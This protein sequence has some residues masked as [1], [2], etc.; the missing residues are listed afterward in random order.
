MAAPHVA[1]AAALLRAVHPDW[2]PADIKS[3]LVSTAFD[4][5]DDV[6][7]QG[8]GR[9]DVS[10]AVNQTLFLDPPTLGFG[11][12]DVER[13]VW[14]PSH[15]VRVTNRGSSPVTLAAPV[16]GASGAGAPQWS[17]TESGTTLAPG[18]SKDVLVAMS[19]DHRGS[20]FPT[21]GS[22]SYAGSV[23]IAGLPTKWAFVK[24]SRIRV[25][26]DQGLPEV[27]VSDDRR[28]FR[29]MT[30]GTHA[31]ESVI[32]AGTYDVVALIWHDGEVGVTVREQL[33]VKGTTA[34]A[35]AIADLKHTLT[36]A[37]V[38]EQGVP[39]ASRPRVNGVSVYKNRLRFVY[40]EGNLNRS[41]DTASLHIPR[42]LASDI[43]AGWR[44]LIGEFYADAPSSTLYSVQHP[45][46][47]G[48]RESVVL[49][50]QPL[51]ERRARVMSPN[52]PG[53]R[54]QVQLAFMRH[55]RF[56]DHSEFVWTAFATP[57]AA[58]ATW[59]GRLFLTADVDATY[60]FSPSIGLRAKNK[61]LADFDPVPLRL[62][63]ERGIA[64]VPGV[65][66]GP[67][68]QWHAP[69][70]TLILGGGPIHP[71]IEFTPL[72]QTSFHANVFFHGANGERR[73]YDLLHTRW[74]MFD[75]AGVSTGS[76]VMEISNLQAQLPAPGPVR[77]ELR[78]DRAKVGAIN[79]RA[80][81]RAWFDTTKPDAMAPSFTALSV[82]NGAGAQVDAL[83]F[84]SD[85]SLLFGIVDEQFTTRGRGYKTI[86]LGATRVEYR[87]SGTS[88]WVGAQTRL[89]VD[90]ESSPTGR[91]SDGA[92]YR[93]RIPALAGAQTVDVRITAE[94]AAGNKIEY[95]LEPAFAVKAST[96]PR[97]RAVRH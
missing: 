50:G 63:S 97:G 92:V 57:D 30:T 32:P 41:I 12:A 38:D 93:S 35:I 25:T 65:A 89:V 6:M 87:V 34:V 66:P 72:T 80:T 84:G 49:H 17:M 7:A 47:D 74:E 10:K 67:A 43:P 27:Y 64:F 70:S 61:I 55:D 81:Y 77:L 29:V 85:A 54:H 91:K 44:L 18:E 11:L 53:E 15:A 82:Q 1:G 90:D 51:H 48:V 21:E 86:N 45:P 23:T 71:R 37:A 19:V 2:T 88:R 60:G 59:E 9:I 33:A 20:P 69:G 46:L 28:Q 16:A 14:S 5:N 78:N 79:T 73:W 42:Y 75:G 68:T 76:G 83:P 39:L 62:F 24:A 8:T 58:S 22:L 96:D 26:T 94:D 4:L 31:A 36:P 95:T 13:D 40:P 56:A 3:A 52:D